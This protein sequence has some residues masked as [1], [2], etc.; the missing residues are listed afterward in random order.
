MKLKKWQITI[1]ITTSLFYFL[2]Y[3]GR[4]NYSITIPY[5]QQELQLTNIMTGLIA[6]TL[7]AGYAI[8]QFI[9]G[10]II[11][12]IGPRIT[13]TIGAITSTILNIT[14]G[15]STTFTQLLTSW[16]LNG[17]TQ[18]YGYGSCCKLYTSW[19]K[20]T[21]RGKPLGFNEALQGF[22]SAIIAP[23]GAYII[24]TYTW[25]HVYWIPV[26]PL[27][28]FA[29]I[30]YTIIR[31]TPKEKGF[32]VPWQT[33]QQK[34]PLKQNIKTAYKMALSDWRM[35]LTYASYG[36]SQYARFAIFTWVPLYIYTIT[37][38]II[39]A[40]WITMFFPLGGA[41]GSFLFGYLSDKYSKRYPL[42]TT[43]MLLSTITLIIFAYLPTAPT[44]IL[45]I[46]MFLCGTGIEAVEVCY[47]L[48]PMDILDEAN[49]QATGVGCMNA[50]GKT[51]ATFQGIIFGFTL[52]ISGF[53]N[54][55]LITAL[56]SL[57][58]SIIV[59]P[60]KK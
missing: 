52:D 33:E 40:G 42:I 17:Y 49:Q 24:T 29:I 28:I 25:R 23:I 26:I 4:Y 30:F 59:I 3:L 1:T 45:S 54:A 19:F 16:G 35:L 18:A 6:T 15:L 21:D 7:T 8:G 20:K 51:F 57:I 13:M 32:N 56:I 5:I 53:Q 47:F 14:M 11:D 60:I 31:N 38:E 2:Y 50:W 12:R 22:S 34:Q 48:L 44:I 41:I 9:N 46:L 55:F 58:S 36:G 39:K 37:G 27:S 43:G 10:F